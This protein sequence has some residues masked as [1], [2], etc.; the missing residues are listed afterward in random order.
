MRMS[1]LVCVLLGTLALGQTAPSAP[2]P[3]QS[4]P[5]PAQDT[6]ASVPD[7]AVVITVV[8]VC[9][10]QPKTA[11]GKGAA[12]AAAAKPAAKKPSG[13]DCKTTITK[14]EFERIAKAVAP[15]PTAPLS[16]QLK[17]QLAGVL[18][19]FIAL[20]DAAKKQGLDKKPE[21]AETM[22]FVKMQVL[23][24]ALQRKV[25]QES[26]EVPEAEIEKYYKDNPQSYEQY[27]LERI[28]VPRTKQADNEVKAE[29]ANEDKEDKDEK[30]TDEQKAA[31]EAAEKAKADESEQAM[32]KLADELRARAA[33]GE[34]FTKLQKAAYD[35][36]GMKIES[37][38]VNLA[39]VRRTNLPPAHASV[40]D[41]KAGDV[42]QVISESGGH[43]IY[44]LV[45]KT[46]LPLDQVKTEIHN[47]LQ[48]DRLRERMDAL[49][50]SFTSETNEAYFGPG[51]GSMP[52]IHMPRQR[53]GMPPAPQSAPQHTP[54]PAQPPAAK[55]D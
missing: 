12:N 37:P 50:K 8:G 43:Y 26:S 47:K 15:N 41:L 4:A 55:Q 42:S 19:R 18:P 52:P 51:G 24:N 11:A 9:P 10:A 34:D 39:N 20:S 29:E 2:A 1:W 27:T 21:F 30:L 48:G 32:T 14:G 45:S 17:R 38:N 33:A 22:K 36:A 7:D 35:A 5:A 28:F 46:Q 3:A 54:P 31:K 16:P 6:S 13:N 25:Q 49:N 53:P 44:K 40:L 23:T